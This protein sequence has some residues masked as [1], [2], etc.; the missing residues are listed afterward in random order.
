[1]RHKVCRPFRSGGDLLQIAPRVV[2]FHAVLQEFGK[3]LDRGQDVVEV[4][5]KPGGDGTQGL[6][7]AFFEPAALGFVIVRDVLQHPRQSLIAVL[8]GDPFGQR[9]QRTVFPVHF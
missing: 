5:G 9:P 6:A 3:T 1:M 4:V 8:G 2:I 7:L